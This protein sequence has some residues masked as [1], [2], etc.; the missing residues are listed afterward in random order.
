[1]Y[2]FSMHIAQD[3]QGPKTLIM[4]IDYNNDGDFNDAGENVEFGMERSESP[5]KK[6][7][8]AEKVTEEETVVELQLVPA[9]PVVTV[10]SAQR[11]PQ[12]SDKSDRAKNSKRD[13]N[14]ERA[15]VVI[16]NDQV[17]LEVRSPAVS[18]GLLR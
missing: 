9:I 3:F 10:Q 6:D 1:M 13:V 5:H 17:V 2:Y 7:G 18:R 12:K 15:A 8:A 16:T 14:G 11:Q 4:F